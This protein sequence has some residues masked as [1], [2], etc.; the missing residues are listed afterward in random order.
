M[1]KR[2]RMYDW[3]NTHL[4]FVKNDMGLL[5]WPDIVKFLNREIQLFI[6]SLIFEPYTIFIGLPRFI[7]YLPR[8]I[9]KRKE[10]M[11]RKKV[12]TEDIKEWYL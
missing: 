6:Y 11:R 5:M 3:T 10:I 1:P 7:K 8:A 12:S 2:K 4:T 9:K